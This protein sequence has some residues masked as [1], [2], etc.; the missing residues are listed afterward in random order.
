MGDFHPL[1]TSHTEHTKAEPY[2]TTSR[3]CRCEGP[4]SQRSARMGSSM[5][6]R[7]AGRYAATLTVN[8]AAEAAVSTCCARLP[9]GPHKLFLIARWYLTCYKLKQ[10]NG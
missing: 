9:N 7:L 10:R 4:Y 1:N 3:L 5:A 6:A 2:A 8:K